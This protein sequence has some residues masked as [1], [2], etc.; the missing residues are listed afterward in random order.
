[1]DF[2]HF[3]TF[4]KLKDLTK[5]H[6][7]MHIPSGTARAGLHLW[8]LEVA[9]NNYSATIVYRVRDGVTH[10][11]RTSVRDWSDV[12]STAAGLGVNVQI[13]VPFDEICEKLMKD[14]KL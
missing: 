4:C 3:L 12:E 2:E 8:K 9:G 11:V 7:E 14:E 13:D 10:I 1:M 5:L 6:A